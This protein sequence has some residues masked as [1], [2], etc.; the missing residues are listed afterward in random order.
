MQELLYTSVPRGLKPGSRGFSTVLSTQG[1]VAP[2]AAALEALSGYRPVFPIG[3]ARVAENPV[4]YSHLKLQVAGKS[5]YVLSRVADYGLDYSQR[6]NKLAHHL[7]LDKSELPSAGPASLLRASGIM[8]ESWEGDPKIVPPKP[9][10]RETSAPSGVCQAWKTMTGDAGWA[11]VLA[12]S[13]LKD[14]NR[15]VILLFEPGQDL[16]PLIDE[17]LSL[18]PAERRWD[19][20][21]NTYFTGS[22]Q[23]ITCLWRGIAHGSK[24]ATESLRFV[25]A[26]RIDLTST[27]VGRAE[28]G[29]LVDAAR[30]GIRLTERPTL[31]PKQTA[32]REQ[33]EPRV[34]VMDDAAEPTVSRSSYEEADT[35]TH[36]A[37]VASHDHSQAPPRL[38]PSVFKFANAPRDSVAGDRTGRK[39]SVRKHRMR[40]VAIGAVVLLIA[41]AIGFAVYL[42]A[43]ASAS[44]QTLAAIDRF[45][46]EGRLV[47]ARKLL[48]QHPSHATHGDWLAVKRKLDAADQKE[49]DRKEELES[50]LAK[51]A[52]AKNADS[53][54]KQLERSRDL[55]STSE[56]KERVVSLVATWRTKKEQERKQELESLLVQVAD[57]KDPD[58]A[59]KQLEHCHDLAS[60]PEEKERVVS[61]VATWRTK[62]EQERRKVAEAKLKADGEA[63][64]KNADEQAAAK[65]NADANK[66][67]VELFEIFEGTS[68]KLKQNSFHQ[69]TIPSSELSDATL[70]L[71]TVFDKPKYEAT[72]SNARLLLKT[73]V[74]TEHYGTFTLTD[75]SGFLRLNFEKIKD[76]DASRF[77]RFSVLRLTS[78]SR[79]IDF[80]FFKSATLPVSRFINGKTQFDSIE[81]KEALD[82]NLDV[83]CDKIEI[84][85]EKDGKHFFQLD[86]KPSD[87][88][89][90]EFAFSGS[91][92]K[93]TCESFSQKK[94][95][96]VITKTKRASEFE[97]AIHCDPSECADRKLK[98]STDVAALVNG[99]PGFV[100]QWKK[101]SSPGWVIL[102][103]T[104][105]LFFEIEK[106]EQNWRVKNS[107]VPEKEDNEAKQFMKDLKALK[108]TTPLIATEIEKANTIANALGAADITVTFSIQIGRGAQAAKTELLQLTSIE[109]K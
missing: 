81:L 61:L 63:A 72:F 17:S 83:R 97:V 68:P 23:G 4:V 12:E 20:T 95:K 38:T 66:H 14:P 74:T 106:A 16:R 47:E 109:K 49:R 84:K 108:D 24:E 101:K 52:V 30:N 6:T 21:F 85:T 31:S 42:A 77:L 27:D 71:M 36:A 22:S 93:K 32:S 50:L 2:L 48:D 43:Q 3:H 91:F 34:V 65:A 96:V 33:T 7:V 13:F 5:W 25:N 107:K 78:G 55:A 35:E 41:S 51:V 45:I 1:M 46:D 105:G 99:G 103:N 40:N 100:T 15:P 69:T 90:S 39:S 89:D 29:E 86:R 11:G 82:Q 104:R 80:S 67:R 9:I 19:V 37:P 28:G 79:V 92:D 57:A 98:L 18:L 62:K 70:N 102:H 64:K 60:T 73:T 87:Q 8:R 56:E 94:V 75:D 54:L 26:L 59:L 10:A 58:S 44:A 76:V 88:K 53:A